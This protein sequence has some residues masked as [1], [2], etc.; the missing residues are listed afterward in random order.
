[1]SGRLPDPARVDPIEAHVAEL[2]AVLR[3]ADRAKSRMLAELREGLLDAATELAPGRG[4]DGA[5]REAVRLF[6][7]VAEL[8]PGFQRE[9]T[10]V[11]ARHT[12]RRILL[13]APLLL[14]CWYVLAGAGAGSTAH[15]LPYAAQVLLAHLGGTAAAT[16]LVAA[17]FLAATGPLARRLATPDRLPTV[18]AWTGTTAAVA[19]ALSAFT[20]TI[21]S[22]L[23]ASWP[24]CALAGAVAI[25][26][27]ARI[28]ASARACRECARLPATA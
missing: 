19:L 13:L 4:P 28:A 26:F 17:A 23:T 18:V 21:A 5:A 6:G 16:A 1:M 11:Q 12:S 27:H 25:V 10:I 14:P 3:G 9:L 24:L 15:R 8:A 20:L 7:S 22:L 2:A